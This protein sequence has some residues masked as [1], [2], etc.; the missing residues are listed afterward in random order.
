MIR[1]QVFL[2]KDL[3]HHI[4]FMAKSERKPEA[5]V[6]RELLEAGL[7]Q[8]T[9]QHDTAGKALL[10]LAKL[11]KGLGIKLGPDASARI[12]DE[13]YGEPD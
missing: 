10:R 7:R 6:V 13:L 12:D 3:K 4:E 9:A 5:Q 1:T 2:T 11:G 8:K